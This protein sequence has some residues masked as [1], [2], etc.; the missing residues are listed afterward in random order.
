VISEQFPAL[1]VVTPL[2]LSLFI[3]VV[4]WWNTKLCLPIVLAALSVCMIS[5]I[6]LLNTV[7]KHGTV[8]YW[9]GMWEPPWGI[10]YMVDHLNALVLITIAFV[11][12]LITI[13]SKKSVEQEF[14]EHKIPQFYTLF[15]IG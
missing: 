13:Y 12:I 8:H 5:A 10:A 7:M 4:G 15:S 9:L 6:G 11:A 2:I 3:P 14:P 1:I